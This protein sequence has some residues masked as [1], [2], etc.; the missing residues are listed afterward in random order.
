MDP[1][2]HQKNIETCRDRLAALGGREAKI[3]IILGSGL[4]G[5]DALLENP[6]RV[7]YADLPGFPKPGVAGHAGEAVV[8]RL[9]GVQVLLYRG[10]QHFYETSDATPLKTMIRTVKALGIPRLFVSNAAG[11]VNRHFAVG[12]LMAISDHVNISGFNPL[13]GDNDEDWG[14]RFPP[15]TNAWDPHLRQLL[16]TAAEETGVTLNE[17]VYIW[18]RGPAFETP[19]E[20]RMAQKIGGDAI[21]MSTVPDLLIARHCGLDVVG[22]S[23][24]TNM[25]AGLSVENLSHAHTLE[26]AGRAA[27]GFETL[28]SHFVTLLP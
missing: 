20:I 13:V 22:C 12:T 27:G 16:R 4:G 10:R 1:H 24:L 9:N 14:P 26:N 25:G 11:S 15:M 19:A 2:Q 6:Q 28:V 8:G 7:S 18:F 5:L 21:G 23:C 17:G 3:A